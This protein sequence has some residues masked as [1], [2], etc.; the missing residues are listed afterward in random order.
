MTTTTNFKPGQ[1]VVCVQAFRGF[2]SNGARYAPAD[3][4]PIKGEIYIVDGIRDDA[5][6]IYLKGFD[7]LNDYGF[8]VSFAA[9]Y[10]RPLSYSYISAT[11]ASTCLKETTIETSDT[12]IKDPSPKPELTPE[13]V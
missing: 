10:F 4:D 11:L 7:Y 1:K 8:R 12:P 9:D 5:P 6:A 2:Y 13:K 3:K